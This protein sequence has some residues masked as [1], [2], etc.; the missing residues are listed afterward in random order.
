[1]SSSLSVLVVDDERRGRKRIVDLLRPREEITDIGRAT[2]G[3]DAI[4]ALRESSYDL[5]FLDVQMPEKT[6][7]EVVETIGPPN[8]PP[9]IFVTAYDQYAI[10]AFE[11]SALDYLLKPFD[12]ERFEE[13]YQRARRM[14]SLHEAEAIAEQLQAVLN[15]PETSRGSGGEPSSSPATEGSYLERINVDLPGKV[16]V[17]SV[18]DI[19][20]ITADDTHVKLHTEEENYLL[21]ERMHVLAERL[22]PTDFVRIH[23]STI[24]RLDLIDE[25]IQ[26]PGGD[27]SVRLSIGRELS[28]GRSRHD[29]LLNRIEGM[30]S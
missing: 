10:K 2:S 1:M 9:T 7:L 12:D 11:Q 14:Q 4:D 30:V 25:V 24:V 5:V 27:Y 21:R 16:Q 18:E 23:R 8:M 29:E 20:Y 3:R 26:R 17:I 22:D 28:V 19:Y 13:A 15:D 6:G